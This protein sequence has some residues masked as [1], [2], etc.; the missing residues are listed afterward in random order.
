MTAQELIGV[1][2]KVG[3]WATGRRE[4]V[5]FLRVRVKVV[6]ARVV[7]GRKDYRIEPT[8]GEGTAWVDAGQVVMDR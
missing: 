3:L 8:D 1:I 4:G 5:R 6:D 7:F 2:G